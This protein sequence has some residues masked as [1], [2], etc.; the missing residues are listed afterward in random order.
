MKEA[1]GPEEP[2]PRLTRK[3]PFAKSP[4][5][6]PRCLNPLTGVSKLGV[7]LIPQDY[8]CPVCGY[9]GKVY[10]EKAAERGD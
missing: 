5:L 2:Q 10:V 9:T 3:S 7:W 4:R 6:C 8:Y 1:D